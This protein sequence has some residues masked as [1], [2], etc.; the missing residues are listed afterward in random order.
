[1]SNSKPKFEISKWSTGQRR[2]GGREYT[3]V[4]V[5]DNRNLVVA[6]ALCENKQEYDEVISQFGKDYGARL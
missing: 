2:A 6:Y 5:R 1:M 3:E 4:R